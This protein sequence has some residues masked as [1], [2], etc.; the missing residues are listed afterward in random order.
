VRIDATSTIGDEG[1]DFAGG[2]LGNV[3]GD[4]STFAS[5]GATLITGSLIIG[6]GSGPS[7]GAAA[8]V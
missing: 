4:G 5:L 2:G 1:G 3:G 7:A 8:T 6:L